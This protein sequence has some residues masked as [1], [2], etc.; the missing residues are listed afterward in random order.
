MLL[1]CARSWVMFTS[2]FATIFPLVSSSLIFISLF[3][4]AAH[5]AITSAP[6]NPPAIKL[7]IHPIIYLPPCTQPIFG[8]VSTVFPVASMHAFQLILDLFWDIVLFAVI[9]CCAVYYPGYCIERASNFGSNL[10]FSF[11]YSIQI[12]NFFFLFLR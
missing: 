8:S 2:P 5:S 12:E 6:A 9:C 11:A 10:I 4:L 1:F 3:L 7:I